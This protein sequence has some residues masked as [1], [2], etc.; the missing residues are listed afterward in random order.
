MSGPYLL[1][2]VLQIAGV[3]TIIAE[4]ILPSG[5]ILS[6][7]AAGLFGVS[8]YKAFALSSQVGMFFVGLDIIMIPALVLTGLKLIAHSPVALRKT[9]SKEE[10]VT[11]QDA[12]LEHFLDESGKAMT[13][14]R[15]AGMVQLMGKRMDAVTQGE[16]I[17]KGT[18]VRVI[19]V[20]GNQI[21]VK[22]EEN[23]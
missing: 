1:P 8:L 10:G 7:I 20:T 3:I 5:G 22:G 21:I 17:D 23:G 6:I 16:Y 4:I 15:P 9:L 14:L 12:G 13:D 19:Q 11:S 18:P 2:I